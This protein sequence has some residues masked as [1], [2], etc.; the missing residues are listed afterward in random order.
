MYKLNLCIIPLQIT[1]VCP[2]IE[3]VEQLRQLKLS[4]FWT[5]PDVWYKQPIWLLKNENIPQNNFKILLICIRDDISHH[6]L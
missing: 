3:N 6:N 2:V 4:I 5:L 1:G